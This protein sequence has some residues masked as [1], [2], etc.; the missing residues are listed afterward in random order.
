MCLTGVKSERNR[1]PQG[2][3]HREHNLFW[4]LREQCK[5][6]GVCVCVDSCLQG[7]TFLTSYYLH[8][9]ESICSPPGEGRHLILSL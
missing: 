4:S 2:Q 5:N 9:P 1:T 6:R 7:D 3:R 8:A